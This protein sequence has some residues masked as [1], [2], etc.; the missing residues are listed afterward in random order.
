MNF[1]LS[2]MKFPWNSHEITIE[3]P[4]PNELLDSKFKAKDLSAAPAPC[5]SAEAR[6]L[7]IVHSLYGYKNGDDY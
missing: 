2:A 3:F 1:P 7:A 6:R 4:F 5:V